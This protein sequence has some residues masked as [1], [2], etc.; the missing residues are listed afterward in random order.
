MNNRLHLW[1]GYTGVVATSASLMLMAA[2]AQAIDFGP[3]GMFSLT[4]FA[5]LKLGTQSNY[6]LNCQVAD[7]SVSKHIK[8][9]DAI[10]PGSKYSTATLTN[11]QIQPYLG[12]KYKL[13]AGYEVSGLLSQRWR[14]GKVNGGQVERRYGGKV[15][16][17]NSWYE[18]NIALSHET[19]GS[20]RVGSMTTRAWNVADYPYGTNVGVAEV[21]ASSGAGYGMLGNAI[22]YGSVQFDVAEGDL[23]VEATYDRG[24]PDFK[25]L[26]PSFFELYAQYHKGDL[27]VDA[28]YQDATNGAA[29]AWG[30]APF[31]G[32]TPF[33]ADDTYVGPGGVA[34]GKNKQRIGMVMARYQYNSKIE[35]SG[36]LRRNYWSGAS[37]VYN[38]ATQWTTAFN[39]DYTNPFSA[40]NPGHP[41]TSVDMMLGLRYRT[42]KW[43]YSTGMVYLGKAS[44]SNPSERGQSNSAL[45]NTLGV[46]YEYMKGV[47]LGAGAGMVRYSRLGLS[48]VSQTSNSSFTNVDSRISQKGTWLNVNLVYTF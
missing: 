13:G 27:V 42:D 45:I 43:T 25:R 1:N 23:F 30:H 22:R 29:G 28:M 32:V 17:P 26:K 31:K 39:V 2:S 47:Q 8:A 7:A 11:W 19:Y 40:S 3:D 36:G 46:Q 41:V 12:A 48:P 15:D 44:T 34:F 14:D 20:V 35:V 21:W 18:K 38:P 37:I 4:G 6:C 9:A 10:I 16:I 33:A 24:N 5:E